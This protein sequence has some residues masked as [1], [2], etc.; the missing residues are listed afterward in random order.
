[1][2]KSWLLYHGQLLGFENLY[3]IDASTN[4]KC[5]SFLRYARD[6]LGAN[7]L[8]N[9]ANLNQL[10]VLMTR[11]ASDISGSSDFIMKVDTDEFLGVYDNTTTALSVDVMEYL[12]GFATNNDHP[13]RQLQEKG[14]SQFGYVQ[15]SVP[16]RYVC[17][18][19]IYATPDQFPLAKTTPVDG[20][21]AVYSSRHKFAVNLGG[22]FFGEGFDSRLVTDFGIFHYHSR[23]VEIEVE[24]CKRVLERHNYI[25]ATGNKDEVRSQLY[26]TSHKIR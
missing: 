2:L 21:K 3:V 19:N 1:M 12:A 8:F 18:D 16:S 20:Y 17:E 23:C 10:E 22:H 25:S 15:P 13:L 9:N 6:V 26:D 14:H 5:F 7:I 24:N 4:P 11:L